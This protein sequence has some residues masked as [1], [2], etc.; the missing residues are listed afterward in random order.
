MTKPKKISKT[1]QRKLRDLGLYKGEI[2]GEWNEEM[3]QADSLFGLWTRQGLTDEQIFQKGLGAPMVDDWGEY[4]RSGQ[5]AKDV[6]NM[7]P[8]TMTA[9]AL[10][11]LYSKFTEADP[12]LSLIHI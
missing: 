4:I 2:G 5:A 9:K 6:N 10:N 8:M 7:M 12:D 1:Y 3:Q 11:M